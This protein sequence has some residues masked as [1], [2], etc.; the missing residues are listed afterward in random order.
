MFTVAPDM[1]NEILDNAV[2]EIVFRSIGVLEAVTGDQGEMFGD[3]ELKGADLK[4]AV[5]DLAGRGVLENL[6]F[7]D[8]LVGSNHAGKIMSEFRREFGNQLP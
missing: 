2:D 7:I 5:I 1:M 3:P 6:A 4:A 8:S